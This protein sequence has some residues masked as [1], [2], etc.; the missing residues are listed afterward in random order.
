MKVEKWLKQAPEGEFP[1]KK[2]FPNLKGEL[3]KS[4]NTI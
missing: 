4:S 1:R 3:Q 2:L